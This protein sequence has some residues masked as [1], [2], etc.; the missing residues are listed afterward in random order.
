MDELCDRLSTALSAWESR[1]TQPGPDTGALFAGM[2]KAL[3]ALARDLAAE[4]EAGAA[5]AGELRE[6][7][8]EVGEALRS[9]R[10]SEADARRIHELEARLAEQTRAAEATAERLAAL[11]QAVAERD[12]TAQALR[13]RVAELEQTLASREGAASAAEE[14]LGELESALGETQRQLD[15]AKSGRQ[16][17]ASELAVACARLDEARTE[18][19][20]LRSP[21]AKARELERELAEE[22]NRAATIAQ[23]LESETS[24]GTKSMIARQLAE[25]LADLEKTQAENAALKGELDGIRRRQEEREQTDKARQAVEPPAPRR[26]QRALE[27]QKRVI[28]DSLL[29]AG[30]ITQEQ[31]DTALEQCQ[32]NPERSLGEVLVANQFASEESVAVALARQNDVP[33]VQIAEGSAEESAVALITGRLAHRHQCIPLRM[34]ENRVVLAMTDPMDLIAIED[35]ERVTGRTVEPVVATPSEIL[36]AIRRCYEEE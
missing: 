27:N 8:M 28:G 7:V 12:T 10:P 15:E 18:L 20:S 22:R 16:A 9:V 5:S 3:D 11:D 30:I 33:F 23:R 29:E 26:P 25:A 32:E 35:I 6:C 13:D 2:H 24:K 1:Q 36:A 19:E 31:L 21:A 17:V 4:R 34:E 14:R